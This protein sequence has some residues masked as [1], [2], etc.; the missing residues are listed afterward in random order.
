MAIEAITKAKVRIECAARGLTSE[1]E[2]ANSLG[3]SKK[4]L[5]PTIR[6]KFI[7]EGDEECYSKAKDASDGFEHGYLDYAE[8]I[9]KAKDVRHRMAR[10]T[11]NA[12]LQWLA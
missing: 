3:I 2:L 5:D 12:I 11:R 1:Q 10:Y 9:S 4:E 7:L 8:V 6:K